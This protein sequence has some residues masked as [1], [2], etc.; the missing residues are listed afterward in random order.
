MNEKKNIERLFQEKFKDFE[1][2][3]PEYVWENIREVLQEKKKKRV[4]PLWMKLSGVAAVLIIGLF[5]GMPFFN[6]IDATVDPVVI[7]NPAP[8]PQNRLKIT[9]TDNPVRPTQTVSDGTAAP[10]EAL[11]NAI[12]SSSADNAESANQDTDGTG[13]ANNKSNTGSSTNKGLS[14]RYKTTLPA[15]ANTTNTA[16]ANSHT[17]GRNNR[18]NRNN[19]N[20]GVVNGD[21]TPNNNRYNQNSIA[22]SDGIVTGKS[23][24][25]NTTAV[26]RVNNNQSTT[27]PTQNSQV[28]GGN[29]SNQGVASGTTTNGS[30]SNTII[31]DDALA[32]ITV[33]T[34]TVAK[35]NEL[36]KLLQEK[37]NGKEEETEE[38]V[39]ENGNKWK[40]KPQLAPVFYNSLSQ[41]SPIDGQFASNSKSYNNDLS[42]GVGVN[43]AVNKR[44]SVRSGI[45]SVNLSYS[46]QNVEFFAS[47]NG[48]NSNIAARASAATIVVQNKSNTTQPQNIALFADQIPQETFNGS[49]LQSTGYVEVPVEVSYALVNNKFGIDVIGGVSTLFLNNNNVSVVSAQGLST[50]VGEAQNLNNIHFSTNV[51]LGFKYRFFNAFEANFEPTFKYQVNTF[52][53]DAGNF[54]PYF[55]GLYSGISFSF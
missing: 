3:P 17:T 9:P 15:T 27:N 16:V 50:N 43:Y 52:S 31:T 28:D 20:N 25:N 38:A 39:A 22:N 49:M 19:A 46:T 44:L 55:I 23:E 54:K 33:D 1:A 41:G 53:R 6:G 32:E 36:E 2:A 26:A 4:V 45:N 51:G 11:D 18:N 8:A 42:Y 10:N 24:I 21:N 12:V 47:L 37:L 14:K 48:E 7:E 29:S 30:N 5:I 13:K 35:E 40:I 34:T